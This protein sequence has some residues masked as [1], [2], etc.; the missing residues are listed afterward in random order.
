MP[1]QSVQQL[2][3]TQDII[4]INKSNNDSQ[5]DIYN[6]NNANLEALQRSNNDFESGSRGDNNST[7]AYGSMMLHDKYRDYTGGN[8]GAIGQ[9]NQGASFSNS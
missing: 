8:G 3:Q 4:N 5:S 9:F 6:M 2:K 7:G 1:I